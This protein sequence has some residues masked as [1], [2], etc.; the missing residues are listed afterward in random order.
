MKNDDAVPLFQVCLASA[1]PQPR[2]FCLTFGLG[3]CLVKNVSTT[4]LVTVL[5]A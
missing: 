2:L 1:S 5:T 3:L 4:S